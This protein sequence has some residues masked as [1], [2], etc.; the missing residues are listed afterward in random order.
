MAATHRC[1]WVPIALVAL[2]LLSCGPGGGG[3][4]ANPHQPVALADQEDEVCG[5]LVREQSAPRS[6]VVHRDGSHFFFC[7]LG[8]MLVHLSV[9]SAHGRA[10][11]I[12]VEVMEPGEDPMQSPGSWFKRSS[13]AVVNPSVPNPHSSFWPRTV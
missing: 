3:D 8:D 9:P 7:S 10:A 12:F 6:Q 4:V 13:P 5:M 1:V 11:A 2:A